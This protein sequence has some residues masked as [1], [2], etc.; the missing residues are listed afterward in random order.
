MK[1]LLIIAFFLSC[2]VASAQITG[3]KNIV[4]KTFELEDIQGVRIDFYAKTTIDC[5]LENQITI[6]ADANLIPLIE[7]TVR[8]GVLYLNQLEWVQ[9]SKKIEILIGAPNLI[10][11][12]SGTHDLT[13]V[14]NIDNEEVRILAPI[15]DLV[16]QGKTQNLSIHAKNASID[17]SDLLVENAE[18]TI[19]GDGK[20]QVSV[21]N[22]VKRNLSEN[23][24]VQLIG[25]PVSII[26]AAKN[27]SSSRSNNREWIGFEIKNNSWKR[28]D[29]VVVG[30]KSDGSQ[31]TYG[32]SMMPG[33][34]KHERWTIGSQVY[35]NSSLG[36]KKLLLTVEAENKNSLIKLFQD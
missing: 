10:S 15:G 28:H 14:K 30:P 24:R 6:K 19:T 2:A 4:S 36:S 34:T 7:R 3:N 25:E 31:F 17:A 35:K 11:V 33:A 22:E 1:S 21:V 12:E 27:S 29:F 26:G 20:A 9:A 18:I 13:T 16:L 23:A 32:F 8:D 5:K